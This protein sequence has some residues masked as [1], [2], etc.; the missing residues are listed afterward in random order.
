M[1]NL[2][3]IKKQAVDQTAH[4]VGAAIILGPLIACPSL[5]TATLAGFGCGV[6]RE[7]TSRGDPVK[8]DNFKR[9]FSSLSSFVDMVFWGVGGALAWTILS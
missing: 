5:A 4:M 3:D 7:V 6:V 8:W 2:F 9:S 1:S